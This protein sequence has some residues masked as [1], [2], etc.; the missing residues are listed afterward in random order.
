MKRKKWMV[1]TAFLLCFTSVWAQDYT[2]L[3]AGN[4]SGATV[5]TIDTTGMSWTV[6]TSTSV[7]T[8][9]GGTMSG[10]Y[11]LAL[12]P[13]DDQMYALY[14]L[15]SN[16]TNRRL[17]T[18][19]P[20]TG[21]ITDIGNAGNLTD[22]DFGPDGQLY[23]TTGS[24]TSYE[25]HAVDKVTAST[26]Y[27]FDHAGADWG[28]TIAYDPFADEMIYACDD[29]VNKIDLGTLTESFF[30]GS[31]ASEC[32]AMAVLNPDMAW[33][34]HY[35]S[36]YTLD[37]S[38]GAQTFVTSPGFNVH[39]M[40]FGPLPCNTLTIDVSM[41]EA[42]EDEEFTLT[43]I[44]ETGGSITWTGGIDNGVPFTPGPP[45]VYEYLPSS[46]SPDDCEVEEPVSIEVIGL[47]TV[48]AGAGDLNFCADESITLSAGG[49][50]DEYVWN[51]GAELD[52][53][54]GPGEYTFSLTGAYTEGG[55]LGESTDE[56]TVTVHEL[57]TIGATASDSPICIGLEVTLNGTGGETY[58]WDNDVEDG[59][60][61][62]PNS[63]GTWTYTVTGWDEFGCEG[64]ATVDVEVV[65]EISLSGTTTLVTEG[66]D[67]EIDI[68]VTGGGGDYSFDWDNDGTGDFDDT[69]DLSGLDAG[70]YTVVV[71]SDAG[72]ETTM[73]F[74]L[75]S[76]LGIYDNGIVDLQV[77][78][79][80]TTDAITIALEG[81]FNYQLLTLNGEV[82][83]NGVATNS[84]AVDLTNYAS[85]VY[86][87][88]INSEDNTAVVKVVKK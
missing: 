4:R 13:T 42:C 26:T 3:Y 21:S 64:M 15:S 2:P 72:C 59:V 83:T 47:P 40:A 1:F 49:D 38:T 88:K 86:F 51:E 57:P 10:I 18:Y 25:F 54:P 81:Q 24:Y 55:C 32:H 58:E 70:I 68:T 46:D 29:R 44:S 60:S 84:Q 74:E 50:A 76:Q 63:V 48:L 17:G 53:M 14:E 22:I 7:T 71:M 36:V 73:M 34:A 5:Y 16:Q 37:L 85:G 43:A 61:F 27:I 12:D 87:V 75:D 67:G 65:D 66:S 62:S 30:S 6:V 80:P 77:Y 82:L 35:G 79:N 78:P 41:L 56:V 20:E 8:D 9:Y 39:A 23:G 69:E 52:L 45:G 28:P 31:T 19:D 33:I 11:G